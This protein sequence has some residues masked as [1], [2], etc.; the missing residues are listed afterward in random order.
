MRIHLRISSNSR[1]VPM[2]YQTNLSGYFNQCLE[3]N[4]FHD[5]RSLYSYSWLSAA[6]PID[7]EHLTF[8]QGTEWF[9]SAYSSPLIHK[10]VESIF[11]RP[12]IA[13]GMKVEGLRLEQ[14]PDFGSEQYFR[15]KTPVFL[16][17]KTDEKYP[18]YVFA[19]ETGADALLTTIMRNKL[20]DAQLNPEG[21][22]VCFDKN[23]TSFKKGGCTYK[24]IRSIG[25]LCPVIVKGSP[26]QIAFAWEVGVGHSTGIGFGALAL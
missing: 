21:V 19:H 18:R 15:V 23:Y 1:P 26:E 8:P 17:Q 24:G 14:T 11:A 3:Q 25:S 12:E 5:S 4:P 7:K 9:I 22:E 20:I 16:K 13:Y 6:K 10:L 2:Y